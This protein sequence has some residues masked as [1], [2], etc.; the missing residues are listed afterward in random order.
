MKK[1]VT[2]N[3][4]PSR[5]S[6]TDRARVDTMHDQD[7]DTRDIPEISPGQFARAAVRMGLKTVTRKKQVTLRIDEDV[8]EWFKRQGPGYQTHINELLREYV[9]AHITAGK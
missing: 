4:P 7:I 5:K 9:K 8:L 3:T 6:R 1:P 2:T